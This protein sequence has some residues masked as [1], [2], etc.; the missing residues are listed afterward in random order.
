MQAVFYRSVGGPTEARW[1]VPKF[2]MF[3]FGIFTLLVFLLMTFMIN[4]YYREH[5]GYG[6]PLLAVRTALMST[7]L[8]PLII[9]LSG[10]VNMV[11]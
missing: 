6:L 4:P 8:I 3:I 11:T 1:G 7:A 5:R 10:R 9:A 2:G